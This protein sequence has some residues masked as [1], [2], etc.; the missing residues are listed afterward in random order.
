M[1]TKDNASSSPPSSTGQPSI[2]FVKSN[3]GKPLLLLNQYLFKCNKTTESKKYW[4][5]IKAGCGVSA[6][7]NLNDEF[8]LI[9]GDHNHVA[10]SDILENKILKEKMKDRILN[11][12]TSITKIYDEEIAKTHLSEAVTA[13]YPTVIEYRTYLN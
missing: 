12:T 7:T 3:K 5:C 9:T 8:L 4:I 13:Q 11:E 6:R 2:S 1:A 10:E